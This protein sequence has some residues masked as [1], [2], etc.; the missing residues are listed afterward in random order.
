MVKVAQGKC[1]LTRWLIQT[2]SQYRALTPTVPRRARAPSSHRP[3]AL[4]IQDCSRS[5][6]RLGQLPVRG[7]SARPTP[8]ASI[9]RFLMGSGRRDH[10]L[11][12]DDV[13]V[14][15]RLAG[16]DDAEGLLGA[17]VEGE[18]LDLLDGDVPA[19]GAVE[20][21]LVSRPRSGPARRACRP[22]ASPRRASRRRS[23]AG[24]A[25]GCASRI[26]GT[27]WPSAR[28]SRLALVTAG[29]LASAITSSSPWPIWAIMYR[30]SGE[31]MCGIRFSMVRH[32]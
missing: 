22:A 4:L 31:R 27:L 6:P 25:G 17:V 29:K 14:E 7:G 2:P 5:P 12:D 19:L 28:T 23:R 21:P 20:Q 16:G 3:R 26:A 13:A 24:R 32:P 15:G 10:A 11:L 1:G 8:P 18:P 30:S 9:R